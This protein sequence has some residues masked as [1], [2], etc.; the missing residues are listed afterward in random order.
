MRATIVRELE[1]RGR[2]SVPF[3]YLSPGGRPFFVS[4]M[5]SYRKRK[6][7]IVM[8]GAILGDII[9]SRFEFD[10][11]GWSKE[12]KLLTPADN[13]TDD[14]VMT[15]AI[16]EALMDAGRDASVEEIEVECIKSM[17]R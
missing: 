17:Q 9:G 15:V 11:G 13:W 16:A 1:N 10:R 2:F 3:F 14:T 12:F 7:D 4:P 5:V 8:Y 6:E